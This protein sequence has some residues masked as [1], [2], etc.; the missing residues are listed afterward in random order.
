MYLNVLHYHLFHLN[1]L[2]IAQVFFI[3]VGVLYKF[4]MLS[5]AYILL[6]PQEEELHSSSR[7][8]RWIHLAAHS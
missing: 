1:T 6:P 5:E 8:D 7:G 4:A 3:S 2:T